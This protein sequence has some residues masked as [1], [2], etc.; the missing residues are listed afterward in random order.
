[1]VVVEVVLPRH[2]VRRPMG[3]GAGPLPLAPE[4]WS[5]LDVFAGAA[6]ADAAIETAL[7]AL[8]A[9]LVNEQLLVGDVPLVQGESEGV[10]RVWDAIAASFERMAAST[11]LQDL[12]DLTGVSLAQIGRD[13]TDL[14]AAYPY[15]G[16]MYRDAARTVRLRLAVDLLSAS[17]ASV[18]D[19]AMAVGY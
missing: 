14:F 18:T 6:A 12:A 4:T 5:A 9:C 10:G 11:T 15:M 13:L 1:A 19:V 3:L 16:P 2:E 8:L 7:E 17:D